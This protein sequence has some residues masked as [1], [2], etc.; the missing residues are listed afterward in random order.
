VGNMRHGG[1][2]L[3]LAMSFAG[4]R[5]CGEAAGAGARPGDGTSTNTTAHVAQADASTTNAGQGMLQAGR[6]PSGTCLCG[7]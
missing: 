6:A 5:G 3:L 7:T 2:W 4:L 1:A